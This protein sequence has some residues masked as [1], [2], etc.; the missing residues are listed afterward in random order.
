M[1]LYWNGYLLDSD[2]FSL[3]QLNTSIKRAFSR[4]FYFNGIFF[5]GKI[6]KNFNTTIF[7]DISKQFKENWIMP[8]GGRNLVTSKKFYNYALETVFFFK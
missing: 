4:N 6:G 2:V 1:F 8:S 5:F 7:F 3:N